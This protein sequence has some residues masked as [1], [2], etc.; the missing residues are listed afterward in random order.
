MGGGPEFSKCGFPIGLGDGEVLSSP[1]VKY[2]GHPP[3]T[4]VGVRLCD[5][6]PQ[7]AVFGGCFVNVCDFIIVV[8]G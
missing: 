4:V 2:V 5:R 1:C 6:V 7:C 3:L 8:R